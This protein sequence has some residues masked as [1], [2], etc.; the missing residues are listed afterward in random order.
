MDLVID[1][2]LKA[3]IPPLSDDERRQLG[4]NLLAYGGAR[5]PLIV[6][7]KN[8]IRTLID[9]HNRYEIC[10]QY[11][12]KFQIEALEFSTKDDA[13]IWMIDNQK[14]RRNISDGW[15]FELA[16]AKKKILAE[17]GKEN[18]RQSLGRG[19]KGLSKVDKPFD[20]NTQQELAKD[21]GWST[22]KVA[23][24][25][26]VWSSATSEVKEKVKAGDV[27]INQAYQEIRKEE[28]KQKQQEALHARSDD[29]SRKTAKLKNSLFDVRRGDF[30][31][32]LHDVEAVSLILTDPPY[33]KESLPL[34]RELGKWA[35]NALADDGI[36]IAYSGQ[37]FLPQVLNHLC[38]HLEYWWCGA[39]VHK[40]NGNLSPLGHP[41]RKVINQWKPLVMFYKRGGVGF[42]R[43][44]RDLLA[45]VGPE[46]TDHNWQQPI[47]E[48]KVL[49]ES[50][51]QLGELVVDPF[52]GSGG[53]CKA[54][55]ECG[56]LAVG[57][58]ILNG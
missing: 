2:E 11:K 36:L 30:R 12:L 18:Q 52:A 45:G 22:G 53:F 39:V 48:A 14:G 35:A 51:T 50:F 55:V 54:A 29:K 32:V 10:T 13:K 28:K 56:R 41:V 24:A 43:T 57:A 9:G 37:M 27:S 33:P 40:G 42:E 31:E 21:L 4:D 19:K 20:H 44:F 16:Q 3:L 15:K 5:D 34:W 38:E 46:K 47:E 1:E 26:K 17:H 58:E 6:W 49:I 25:D 23:M 8:G 7:L